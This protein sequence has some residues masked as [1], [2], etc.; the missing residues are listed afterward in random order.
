MLGQSQKLPDERAEQDLL[1]QSKPV[2]H[3]FPEPTQD[4]PP[5]P[6]VLEPEQMEPVPV[7]DGKHTPLQQ[8]SATVHVVPPVAHTA[9]A[10]LVDAGVARQVPSGAQLPLQHVSSRPHAAPFG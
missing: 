3:D 5:P 4:V 9:P 8:S 10:S 1:Q 6:P 7:G 2:E